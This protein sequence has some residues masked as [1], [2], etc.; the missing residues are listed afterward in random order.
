MNPELLEKIRGLVGPEHFLTGVELSPYVLEGRT[1][2]AAVFPGSIEEISAILALAS[3][4]EV[5]VTPWGGGTKMAIGSP[6][7]RVG[8]VL[9]LKRLGRLIEHE[10]GDLT[11]TVQAGMSLGAFQAEVGRRGQWLSLDPGFAEQATLGGILATNASGPRRHLY[12]TAR[13]LLIGVTV[14]AADGSVVRGGGK[15]VKNVAGYD[16]PKLYIGSFGTL[17]VI[18]EATFKLRPLPDVDRC[19]LARFGG[20]KECGLALKELLTSDLIPSAVELLDSEAARGAGL[21]AGTDGGGTLLVGFDGLEAQVGWQCEEARRLF[22][23]VGLVE[24]RVLDGAARDQAWRAASE[25][26]RRVVAE[27]AAQMKLAVLPAHVTDVIEQA[28]GVAQRH[29]LG[30]AFV[31]HAGIGIA[32][33]VLTGGRDSA[34]AVADVLGEWREIAKAAGGSALVEWAPL[35]VKEAA[36]VWD[37]PGPAFRIMQRIKA[38][39]DPRGILNPGRFV[40]GI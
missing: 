18:V 31:A 23:A 33:G 34:R 13:D 25:L 35:A 40:G 2:D 8:L 21:V 12:G 9:G 4:A 3:E 16:L 20:L 11:A 19:F 29:S 5:P 30:A 37:P 1:P 6:P 24:H 22:E 36:A 26:P 38:Q 27:A 14:V 10:P 28:G 17:G 7:T 32:R 15:V 39:L